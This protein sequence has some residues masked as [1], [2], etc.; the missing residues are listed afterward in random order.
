MSLTDT[1]ALPGPGLQEAIE[2]LAEETELRLCL[3]CGLCSG[4]CPMARIFTT[5]ESP[6]Y[7]RNIL[8]LALDGKLDPK[9]LTL[10]YCLTC[11]TCCRRCPAGVRFRVFMEGLRK[12][13]VDSG[14]PTG[15]HTCPCCGEP[16]EGEPRLEYL[17]GQRSKEERKA[18]TLCPRCRRRAAAGRARAMQSPL[19]IGHMKGPPGRPGARR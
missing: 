13:L 3:Q 4:V 19:P 5:Y 6:L 9:D 2:A 17:Q 7:P 12:L 11:D 15:A 16:F 1:A 14:S 10:W 8:T 18:L